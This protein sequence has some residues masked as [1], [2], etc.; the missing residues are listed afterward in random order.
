MLGVVVGG[1]TG[2]QG[3]FDAVGVAW[4][5]SG[6]WAMALASARGVARLGD[7]VGTGDASG[8]GDGARRDRLDPVYVPQTAAALLGPRPGQSEVSDL[9][10]LFG[11]GRCPSPTL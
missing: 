11:R 4:G 9:A 6:A 10:G 1:P 8:G 3:S 7:G 5:W 2:D